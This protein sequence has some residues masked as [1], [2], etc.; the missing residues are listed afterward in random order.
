[1]NP[2]EAIRVICRSFLKLASIYRRS[3]WIIYTKF[4]RIWRSDTLKIG[5]FAFP[6]YQLQNTR[7]ISN[8]AKDKVEYTRS[9]YI[10]NIP[11]MSSRLHK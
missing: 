8:R 1:M 3:E 9:T 10:I 7:D 11:K 4:Y 2:P 5:A 6:L